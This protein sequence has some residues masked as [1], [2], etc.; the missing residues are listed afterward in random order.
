MKMKRSI[1]LCAMAIGACGLDIVVAAESP[2]FPIIVADIEIVQEHIG[3]D[4]KW[5][6]T[7]EQGIYYRNALGSV[8]IEN[9]RVVRIINPT[10][11]IT[12]IVDH[13]QQTVDIFESRTAHNTNHKQT[14]IEAPSSRADIGGKNLGTSIV[15]GVVV[16]GREYV[17]K[18]TAVDG[19][20][21]VSDI[22]RTT[23]VW[24]S[25]KYKL[26]IQIVT[27][28]MHDGMTMTSYNNVKV[29]ESIDEEL[30]KI[31]NYEKIRYI[32]SDAK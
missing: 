3:P 6:Q 12:V 23:K 16:S 9:G 31:P 25:S 1:F 2:R 20:G 5:I 15:D 14:V 7:K 29:M 17:T 26:P 11:G 19:S 13:A 28:A 22:E 21:R 24:Y 32:N 27:E 18:Y 4:N 8:R 30:F 10:R